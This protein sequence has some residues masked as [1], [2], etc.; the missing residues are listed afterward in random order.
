MFL[1]K[2]GSKSCPKDNRENSRKSKKGNGKANPY[3]CGQDHLKICE[4]NIPR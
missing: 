4:T 3:L 1:L 2:G